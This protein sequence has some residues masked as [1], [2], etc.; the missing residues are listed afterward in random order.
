MTIGQLKKS[1]ENYLQLERALSKNSVAAYLTDLSLL[2]TFLTKNK[3]DTEITLIQT[4]QIRLFIHEISDM[5]YSSFSQA[6]IIS[7]IKAFFK[8]ALLENLIIS[9]PSELIEGPTIQRKIPDTLQLEEIDQLIAAIDLS[10]PEGSRNKAIIET[11]YSCGLRVTELITLKITDIYSR[12]GFIKVTG[13]G[14][15]ERL[16][17][18]GSS[19]LELI[20][21]YKNQIRSL[22]K[23]DPKYD[24]ILF[25]N[26]RGKGLSRVMI[27][28]I[29]KQ[30]AV[31]AGIKK[32]I[33]P[34]TFRHSF[35]SH[36]VER[37]ADLRAVQEMLGHES[38][39]TTEIYTHLDK[40]YLK[41]T[42]ATYH[43]RY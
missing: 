24:N 42:L 19:T 37:G 3:F 18:I 12:E 13:K 32:N 33:S 35:A 31:R 30:L 5:E 39:S 29:I 26:R 23:I 15:K 2:N 38:I 4:E 27:F 28:T 36:L 41:D 16:I 40:S 1:F 22:G 7:G 14:D 9:D 8:F 21:I 11:L 17:P 34:H 20:D 6:R 43:P 25:L 10:T